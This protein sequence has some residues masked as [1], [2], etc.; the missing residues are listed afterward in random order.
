MKRRWKAK[1][2]TYDGD[3]RILAGQTFESETDWSGVFPCLG[4]IREDMGKEGEEIKKKLDEIYER[5]IKE[6]EKEAEMKVEDNVVTA[7][8][9]LEAEKL[10]EEISEEKIETKSEIEAVIDKIK[11]A[12]TTRGRKRKGEK[13]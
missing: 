8:D 4:T 7:E 9:K 12:T 2:S 10:A 5:G 13:Q 11:I 6:M 3:K 1:F